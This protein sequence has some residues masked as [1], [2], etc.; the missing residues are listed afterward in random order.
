[1]IKCVDRD[2]RQMGQNVLVFRVVESDAGG[3]IVGSQPGQFWCIHIV[4]WDDQA[5]LGDAVERAHDKRFS[6]IN[7]S[8][9][10]EVLS[11]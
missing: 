3:A 8:L 2:G 1:V 5:G 4:F 10:W 9:V 11:L 6:K 7:Q